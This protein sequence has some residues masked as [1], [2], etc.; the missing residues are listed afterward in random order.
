[1]WTRVYSLICEDNPTMRTLTFDLTTISGFETK[2][3]ITLVEEAGGVRILINPDGSVRDRDITGLFFDVANDSIVRS[4][5]ASGRDVTAELFRANTVN[6]VGN[7]SFPT[8]RGNFD[9]GVAIGT[10]GGSDFITTTEVFIAG[11]SLTDFINQRFGL[12]LQGAKGSST[13]LGTAG[14]GSGP[15]TGS[16]NLQFSLGYLGASE[17][18]DATAVLSRRT[19]SDN[20]SVVEN[21]NAPDFDGNLDGYRYWV[22]PKDGAR[23]TQTIQI[24]NTG[25]AAQSNISFTVDADNGPYIRLLGSFT[26]IR[27]ATSNATTGTPVTG[28][29]VVPDP[30][31]HQK[32]LITFSGINLAPGEKLVVQAV[33]EVDQQAFNSNAADDILQ[34]NVTFSLEDGAGA[35]WGN[36]TGKGQIYF[37][38]PDFDFSNTSSPELGD[39]YFRAFT[40]ST[41]IVDPTPTNSSDANLRQTADVT[42]GYVE[43]EGVDV[44]E[45]GILREKTIFLGQVRGN[46]DALIE[47]EVRSRSGSL[48]DGLLQ[49]VWLNDPRLDSFL[50]AYYANQNSGNKAGAYSIFAD[51]I[52][53]G[54]LSIDYAAEEIEKSGEVFSGFFSR[55]GEFQQTAIAGNISSNPNP[56]SPSIVRYPR[57]AF[58]GETFQQFVNRI[59]ARGLA[60]GVQYRVELGAELNLSSNSLTLQNYSGQ[61]ISAFVLYPGAG[62]NALPLRNGNGSDSLN[63]SNVLIATS[64]GIDSNGNYLLGRQV[65]ISVNV[66]GSNN[67][68]D[69]ITGTSGNDT[70]V[71]ANGADTL[72]G[73][74]GNDSL[75]G[76]A[77]PDLLRG[78][79][80]N[81]SL[82]GG[83]GPDVLDGGKG[84]DILTGGAGPDTFV[85]RVGDGSDI[86][87]DFVRSGSSRDTIGLAN[88]LT[89]NQLSLQI[90]G[91]NGIIKYQNTGEIL[92]VL[93]GVTSLSNINFV[94]YP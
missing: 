58:P 63:L 50:D 13:L 59:D 34:E 42:R 40:G 79:L 26:A 36:G 4:F 17:V 82:N 25:N 80:G 47:V 30:L 1:M 57:D 72:N 48:L 67:A 54:L 52:N 64:T 85:I 45:G 41:L 73:G 74:R 83:D 90:S 56:E 6:S 3:S 5:D 55:T 31:D 18:P 69:S 92:A 46:V 7:V 39:F 2:I 8:N 66:Q 15:G 21:P 77:G 93:E 53:Q 44:S 87:K 76:A 28:F 20:G 86:I 68:A 16:P 89:Q 14:G 94:S 60:E 10:T 35:D 70:I 23:F 37:N 43:Y 32:F 51:L 29:S 27:Y 65:G 49:L 84:N 81:D 78:G 9:A 91:G 61:N 24:Q 38:L 71:G 33:S 19:F 12:R 11:A 88:G 62:L 75:F 22:Q